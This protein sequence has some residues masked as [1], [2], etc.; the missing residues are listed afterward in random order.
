MNKR[1]IGVLTSGGDASGMN[2]AIRTIVRTAIHY[3]MEPYGIFRGYHG[4]VHNEIEPL[5]SRSVSGIIQRGG[6]ILKSARSEEFMTP[7]GRKKAVENL[8]KHGID[9]LVVIGGDGSFRG[10]LELQKLGC[11]VI[12]VPAT[13]D[14]DIA[15]TDYSIGFD[16][17]VNTVTDAINKIRDTA[18]SHDRVYVVEV[19]GRHSGYIAL[20]SGLASGA[21][22][23]LV[24]EVPFNLDKVCNQIIDANKKGKTHSIIVAAE[25]VGVDP[26]NNT[27]IESHSMYIGNYIQQKT[28]YE[29]RITILGHIQRGGAPT[30]RDRCLASRLAYHAVELIYQGES[31]KMIGEVD[32]V[33]KSWDLEYALAQK[34]QFNLE[35]YHLSNI[36][37]SI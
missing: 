22:A 34:K 8:K 24:P 6:T 27:K 30:V 32:K 14:N 15:C 3:G 19:M 10:G 13:I 16:T 36:L 31:G 1:R 26:E 33:I 29:T 23:I 35:Y 25:G 5:N 28:G 7:E 11:D 4:L 37:S 20:Y 9:A 12:G 21:D 2:A 17:A 18:S